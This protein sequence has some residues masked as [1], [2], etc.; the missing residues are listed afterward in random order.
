[1]SKTD[2][3]KKKTQSRGRGFKQFFAFGNMPLIFI[4]IMTL[5]N[6]YIRI[7]NNTYEFIISDLFGLVSLS[8]TFTLVNPELLRS[9]QTD[10][11]KPN[12][13]FV[14]FS[15]H[16]V[17]SPLMKYHAFKRISTGLI[18]LLANVFLIINA[19]IATLW[20]NGDSS[21]IVYVLLFL[22]LAKRLASQNTDGNLSGLVVLG[23]LSLIAFTINAI[24]TG[25][26]YTQIDFNLAF[27]A[28]I[29]F[30]LN[31]FMKHTTIYL[32]ASKVS[33]SEKKV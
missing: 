30:D 13:S 22:F 25:I 12:L 33:V 10:Y 15:L 29:S 19:I 2:N 18:L 4:L 17:L 28:F 1:M 31:S 16:Q 20:Y 5:V 23:W 24:M 6:I 26:W 14:L 11:K 9:N 3:S 8:L 27:I 21:A 7:L 32:P